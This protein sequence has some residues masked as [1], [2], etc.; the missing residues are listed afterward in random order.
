MAQYGPININVFPVSATTATLPAGVEIGQTWTQGPHK[1]QLV[2]NA[3][4]SAVLSP[5]YIVVASGTSGYSVTISSTTD[6]WAKPFGVVH[7]TI[8]SASYGWVLKG[9]SIC[10]LKNSGNSAIA[11]GDNIVPDADGVVTKPT[12]GTGT[13]GMAAV[14]AKALAATT[15]AAT[16]SAYVFQL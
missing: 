7:K 8:P 5:G 16:F 6:P 1:Y 15:T 3:Q 10:S 14:F 13:T 9:G 2:Y 12:G 11:A 4:A